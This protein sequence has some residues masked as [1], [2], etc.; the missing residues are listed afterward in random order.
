MM[1]TVDRFCKS[2]LHDWLGLI[3]N[4]RRYY[5]SR[6]MFD[7]VDVTALSSKHVV[8]AQAFLLVKR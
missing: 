2:S 5:H 7:F 8:D 4:G 3:L 1:D 6:D